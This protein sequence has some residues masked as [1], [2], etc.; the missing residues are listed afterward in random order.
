MARIR[1]LYQIL[2]HIGFPDEPR[3]ECHR[4]REA[5]LIVDRWQTR[6]HTIHLSPPEV[7]EDQPAVDLSAE[8]KL[9]PAEHT[10]EL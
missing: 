8:E 4:D 2:E 5:I 9:P 6:P 10:E 7:A 1:L 3:L